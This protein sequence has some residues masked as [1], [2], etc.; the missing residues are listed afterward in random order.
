MDRRFL[1]LQFRPEDDASQGEYDAI[2]RFGG[3]R[4]EQAERVRM[5]RGELPS[6]TVDR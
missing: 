1:I 2:L 3:I 6:E 4:P 5:E